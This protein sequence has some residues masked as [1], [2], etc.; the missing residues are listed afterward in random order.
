MLVTSLLGLA[1]VLIAALTTIT[2]FRCI[3]PATA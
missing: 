2:M 1:I 3:R